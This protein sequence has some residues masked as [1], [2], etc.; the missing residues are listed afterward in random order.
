MA[1]LVSSHS[2]LKAYGLKSVKTLI[3]WTRRPEEKN[4]LP[5]PVSGGKGHGNPY[6]WLSSELEA[7]ERI[8]FRGVIEK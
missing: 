6:R 7:W 4:P 5:A 1:S 8:E 2:L 3:S